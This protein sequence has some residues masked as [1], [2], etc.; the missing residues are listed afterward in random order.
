M[1]VE[2]VFNTWYNYLMKTTQ[3]NYIGPVKPVTKMRSQAIELDYAYSNKAEEIDKGIKDTIKGIRLS[4]LAMGIGLARIKENGLYTDLNFRSM[5]GY[6]EQ[7]CSEN[8]MDRSSMFNWLSI[9]EAYLRYQNDLKKIGFNDG[10]GPTKLAYIDRALE[11]NKK[12]EVFKNIKNMSVR[13]F[14]V[15]SKGETEEE[16]NKTKKITARKNEIFIGNKQAVTLSA[17]LDTKTFNYL[18][19]IILVAGEALEEGEVILPIRLYDTEELKTVEKAV[20]KL[21]KDLRKNT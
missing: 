6:I 2:I 17:E 11:A 21:V 7:L 14:K 20:N 12:Q 18:K 9:G 15:F 10:D 4:I 1:R 19:K 3:N 5:N 8:K 13:E 16:I